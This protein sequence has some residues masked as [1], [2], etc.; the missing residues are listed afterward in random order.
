MITIDCNEELSTPIDYVTKQELRDAQNLA[1]ARVYFYR[2]TGWMQ[3]SANELLSAAYEGISCAIVRYDRHKGSVKETKFTSFAYFWINKKIREYISVYKTMLSGKLT[4]HV[5]QR[6][7]YTSSFES[8]MALTDI[9]DYDHNSFMTDDNS[10]TDTEIVQSELNDE[11]HS[12]YVKLLSKLQPFEALCI[13][14]LNGIGTV[15]GNSMTIREI[16]RATETTAAVVQTNIDSAI[17]KLK[18]DSAQ[19]WREYQQCLS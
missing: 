1:K 16:A 3:F 7:P 18:S 12:I 8:I 6:V 19:L 17:A 11:L 5:N 9:D 13:Q 2:H 10:E 15:S 4:D 14:L